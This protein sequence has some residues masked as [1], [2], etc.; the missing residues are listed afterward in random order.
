[1]QDFIQFVASQPPEQRIN[2][3]SW[4]SCALGDFAKSIDQLPT[5]GCY[6]FTNHTVHA[7]PRSW[8][9]QM[10]ICVD[11]L[12]DLCIPNTNGE[13]TMYDALDDGDIDPA[14]YNGHEVETYGG[15]MKLIQWCIKEQ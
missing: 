6:S 8:S 14:E 12:R 10:E 9:P 2:H 7:N 4:H 5:R 13:V 3:T 11:N 1:M 15:L